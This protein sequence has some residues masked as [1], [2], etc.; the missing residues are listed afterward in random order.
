M[1]NNLFKLTVG[2]TKGVVHM[3]STALVPSSSHGYMVSVND[4]IRESGNRLTLEKSGQSEVK[5]G[6]DLWQAAVADPKWLGL[7]CNQFFEN[8]K[9]HKF[10]EGPLK[11]IGF[12]VEMYDTRIVDDAGNVYNAG[13]PEATIPL[14]VAHKQVFNK[15]TKKW[16]ANKSVLPI[17]KFNRDGK[18]WNATMSLGAL[19]V[20]NLTQS[21]YDGNFLSQTCYEDVYDP[22]LRSF[23]ACPRR[24][25]PENMTDA[26]KLP[27]FAYVGCTTDKQISTSFTLHLTYPF[28]DAEETEISEEAIKQTE[29][30][31]RV[32]IFFVFQAFKMKAYAIDSVLQSVID[33]EIRDRKD[34]FVNERRKQHIKIVGIK[35]YDE[36]EEAIKSFESRYPEKNAEIMNLLAEEEPMIR[37][38]V[39]TLKLY[40]AARSKIDEKFRKTTKVK[41]TAP[42]GAVIELTFP[43]F[44]VTG[45]K[46]NA[47][48]VSSDMSN[49]LMI[50]KRVLTPLEQQLQ[51]TKGAF[52]GGEEKHRFLN[53]VYM[54]RA[55]DLSRV[56]FPC[57]IVDIPGQE[58]LYVPMNDFRRYYIA[59]VENEQGGGVSVVRVISRV[60]RRFLFETVSL[61]LNTKEPGVILEHEACIELGVRPDRQARVA[62]EEIVDAV[63]EFLRAFMYPQ[64]G[65][66]EPPK[67]ADFETLLDYESDGD[68]AGSDGDSLYSRNKRFL[69]EIEAEDDETPMEFEKFADEPLLV[70]TPPPDTPSGKPTKKRGK[71]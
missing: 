53:P 27:G 30:L 34:A 48:P 62:V 58:S 36:V 26:E 68:D 45:K 41:R 13:P 63:P 29:S 14:V 52:V 5:V 33:K 25:K 70:E 59:E 15:D 50:E 31:Y 42:D 18:L 43:A 37:N 21:M 69:S 64:Q 44:F 57:C 61:R 9:V 65:A 71:K 12:P 22:G 19:E 32:A 66:I 24:F 20:G 55:H 54:H 39:E 49:E 51:T 16:E 67:P 8:Q 17:L 40:E 10:R 47:L 7:T 56:P 35:D 3:S 4:L 2:H 28:V 6:F 1:G 23:V 11:H 46:Y 60:I 38:T